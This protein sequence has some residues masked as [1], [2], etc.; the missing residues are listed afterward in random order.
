M[1][2]LVVT[3]CYARSDL[4]CTME[5]MVNFSNGVVDLLGLYS[6]A[7]NL[8]IAVIYRQP[9]DRAGGH[10]STEKEFQS[11]IDK[12]DRSLSDLPDPAPNVIFCGDFNV[13]NAILA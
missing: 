7:K 8:Y 9:D 4:A 13:R 1:G 6:K 11:A 5:I 2:E 3:G 10:Q 12:L